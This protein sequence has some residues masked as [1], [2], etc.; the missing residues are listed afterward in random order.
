MRNRT[1]YQHRINQAS[2]YAICERATNPSLATRGN[3]SI[4]LLGAGP[5]TP[6]AYPDVQRNR[7]VLDP[8][9]DPSGDLR[10]CVFIHRQSER[11]RIQT[12]RRRYAA[13]SLV[14]RW[15]FHTTRMEPS[16]WTCINGW[17]SE[18]ANGGHAVGIPSGDVLLLRLRRK[19]V[20]FTVAHS[21]VG[22][23]LGYSSGNRSL[24]SSTP[25]PANL[26]QDSR[27]YLL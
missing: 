15:A 9:A 5:T 24:V 2:R 7:L 1:P 18:Q 3:R 27:R 11:K 4:E 17:I 22:A 25:S 10:S 23:V 12:H 21:W 13:R 19:P 26:K 6:L 14:H 8:H 16:R 20:W